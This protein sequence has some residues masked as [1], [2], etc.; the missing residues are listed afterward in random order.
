MVK[1][2]AISVVKVYLIWNKNS[3]L[4]NIKIGCHI[5]K[6]LFQACLLLLTPN[7]RETL[8]FPF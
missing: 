4:S 2:K 1:N 8:V 7:G 5:V 6:Q 3:F